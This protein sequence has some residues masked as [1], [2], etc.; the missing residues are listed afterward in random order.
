MSN[1]SKIG[2]AL[3]AVALL[4][5]LIAAWMRRRKNVSVGPADRRFKPGIV[6]KRPIILW[7]LGLGCLALVL[8]Q[9]GWFGLARLAFSLTQFVQSDAGPVVIVV[10][11][12]AYLWRKWASR[13]NTDRATRSETN[14]VANGSVNDER[15]DQ[16]WAAAFRELRLGRN[17]GVW[18]E[19][20]ERGRGDDTQAS[21]L[22]L[23]SR[24]RAFRTGKDSP[25]GMVLDSL[26]NTVV[27]GSNSLLRLLFQIARVGVVGLVVAVA[28]HW[29]LEYWQ[30][31]LLPEPTPGHAFA[32]APA[33]ASAREAC[34][35]IWNIQTRS[36]DRLDPGRS[37]EHGHAY[38]YVAAPGK[39]LLVSSLVEQLGKAQAAPDAE[40]AGMI[41]AIIHRQ[42]AKV[43][44]SGATARQ[45]LSERAHGQ[46]LLSRCP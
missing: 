19:A 25:T 6:L 39:E 36:F 20:T 26:T 28:L 22:Y 32:T 1:T 8:F 18:K 33:V 41:T 13:A 30:R 3:L 15:S 11:I 4:L 12:G 35:F 29:G 2:L 16:L 9:I 31:R 44:Y 34:V 14:G 40:L 45:E 43:Y 17:D 7:G 38:V 46:D 42:A 21:L 37:P 24:V 10:L 23:Q 5:A 27:E